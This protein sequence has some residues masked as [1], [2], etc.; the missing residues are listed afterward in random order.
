M[1]KITIAKSAGFCFGVKRAIDLA[2]DI[3]SKNSD[4]Y[5]FGPLIHNPQEVARLEKENIKV[6]EDY[7]KIEKGVLVLR[8]HGIPLDIYENLSKKENIKIVDAACP[9]VKKAQDIIKELSKDSEQIVIVG[10]KKHPEVVALV[11]YGKGKCLVVEDK[12]D[13]KNVKKT[14]II[15]IVSQTTQSPK[16]FEE[17]VNEISKIS[18][19][20]VFN[21]ICRATFD[22][23]SA[24]AKLAK[25]VD[26]MIVIGGKN[27]GNTTRLYQICSNITKTYHIEDVDEIKPAWFDKV[28]SVGIT[29]GASTPDWIIENIKRRI[30]EIT[31]C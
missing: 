14:D 16:K 21:T 9:F 28:E 8:T 5:T 24:A 6:I 3:A 17:I 11:S 31:N 23:Q 29:A 12:N 20:K 19:V 15:Y 13:V 2:Q 10:E 27:S 22:R 7:S 30:K 26:V 1:V 18:Q 4:V 25:E